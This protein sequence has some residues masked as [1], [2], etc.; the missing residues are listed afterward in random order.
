M[1]SFF[2][3]LGKTFQNA[4]KSIQKMTSDGVEATK[5]NSELRAL[6]DERSKLFA[7]LGE[8]YY[9]TRGKEGSAEQLDL[10]VRRIDELEERTQAVRAELDALDNKQRC[11][12]CNVAVDKSAKFCPSCGAKMPEAAPSEQEVEDNA[13][14]APAAAE[15]C[16]KC[17]A[18]RQG[19]AR[20]CPVCGQPYDPEASKPEI[21]INWPEADAQDPAEEPA[22]EERDEP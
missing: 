21:E 22:P 5:L 7:S 14:D 20:F 12:G 1:A 15:Y 11:P 16:A 3:D 4:A 8:A 18:L 6:R 10:L 19:E 17:G 9:A 13:G 2:S